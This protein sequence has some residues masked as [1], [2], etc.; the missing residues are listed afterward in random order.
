MQ[1]TNQTPEPRWHLDSKML[2]L[3]IVS[4]ANVLTSFG[5]PAVC[6]HYTGDARERVAREL[7]ETVK[8][9]RVGE[10]NLLRMA[11]ALQQPL[12][13]ID[14]AYLSLNRRW[15]DRACAYGIED[16][17]AKR[18]HRELTELARGVSTAGW[19]RINNAAAKREV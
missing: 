10:Y 5:L 2:T 12:T 19:I 6:R 16:P 13:R 3:S 4:G 18:M 1:T 8:L 17:D 7:A 14:R 11:W 15:Y 9:Q